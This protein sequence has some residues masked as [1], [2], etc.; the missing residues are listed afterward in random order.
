MSETDNP[1]KPGSPEFMS[2]YAKQHPDENLR[3]PENHRFAT[4]RACD[5]CGYA[6]WT[7]DIKCAHCGAENVCV[8]CY[9]DDW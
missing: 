3:C 6:I 5:E 1:H 2:W 8:E 9:G 7:D 4:G